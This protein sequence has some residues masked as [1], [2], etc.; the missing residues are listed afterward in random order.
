MWCA[1]CQAD[2]AA[3]V[4]PDNR[5][6]LCAAC[7]SAIE[8]SP[9]LRAAAKTREAREL[10][11]R[12]S[13]GQMFDP[14]G[15]SSGISGSPSPARKPEASAAIVSETADGVWRRI[16]CPAAAA[17]NHAAEAESAASLSGHE[18]GP[19]LSPKATAGVPLRSRERPAPETDWTGSGRKARKKSNGAAL[20]GQL[21]AYGGVLGLTVGTTMVIW[22]YYGGAAQ[23]APTG[24]LVN[25]V[26]QMLLFLGVVTLVS[27]G[28]E[29]TS[30]EVT[31][32]VEELNERL[33]AIELILER[34]AERGTTP[35]QE[36]A[37]SPAADLPSPHF[38]A[39]AAEIPWTTAR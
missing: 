8:H 2:V 6:I 16:D 19:S 11:T 36:S 24:W 18:E 1:Q 25:T 10:L 31:G 35:V 27:G 32:R 30:D 38:R 23:V 17:P 37:P 21:L 7:G 39:A 22:G 3:E 9:A 20:T 28:M 33:S 4:T 5:R 15:P 13:S 14:Y 12:W 29:T 26:G 34:Q